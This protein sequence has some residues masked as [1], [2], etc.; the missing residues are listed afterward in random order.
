M[1][2]SNIKAQYRF[3]ERVERLHQGDIFKDIK[4]SMGQEGKKFLSFEIPCAIIISQECDLE[5][6]E[7]NNE[8]LSIL[9]CPAFFYE[10]F[11][12]ENSHFNTKGMRKKLEKNDEMKRYHYLK[13]DSNFSTPELMIDFK[14][15]LTVPKKFIF[16]RDEE[17]LYVASLNEIFREHFSQR[18]ANYLSRIGLPEI[19][20]CTEDLTSIKNI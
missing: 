16:N 4:I 12:A 11:L 18:F 9:I 13:G 1:F 3:R 5:H 15:Y 20:F 14:Q 10:D 8:L 2:E 6:S 19:D 17:S 7:E